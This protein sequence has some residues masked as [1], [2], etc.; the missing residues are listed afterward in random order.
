MFRAKKEVV[1]AYDLSD[2]NELRQ[3]S[4][5]F[6]KDTQGKTFIDSADGRIYDWN[7]EGFLVVSPSGNPYPCNKDVFLQGYGRISHPR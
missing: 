1:V 7:S 4:C 3:A 6:S 5:L 2:I